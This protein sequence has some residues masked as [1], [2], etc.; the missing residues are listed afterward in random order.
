MSKFAV[1][2]AAG[3][4]LAWGRGEAPAS[5]SG[6]TVR[7]AASRQPPLV[8]ITTIGDPSGL[9]ARERRTSL[10][11]Q[12]Q[13]ALESELGPHGTEI[14]TLD[15]KGPCSRACLTEAKARAAGE[16]LEVTLER[17]PQTL[18]VVLRRIRTRTGSQYASVATRVGSDGDAPNLVQVLSQLYPPA[19][20]GVR[21]GEED[22]GIAPSFARAATAKPGVVTAAPQR[23]APVAGGRRDQRRI[24]DLVREVQREVEAVR[25][26]HSPSPL[27]VDVLDDD[28]FERAL[29]R[30]IRSGTRKLVEARMAKWIAFGIAPNGVDPDEAEESARLGSGLLGFYDPYTKKLYVRRDQGGDSEEDN[31]RIL[32]RVVAHEIEHALQDQAFHFVDLL[33]IADDE[34]RLALKALYE[35]EATV[36]ETAWEA[37]QQHLPLRFAVAEEAAARKRLDDEASLH[38]NG[39]SGSIRDAP[40]ILQEE[41]VLQYV[42]GFALVAEVLKN[43]GFRSVDQMF[44]NPP[45]TTAQVSDPA[46]YFRGQMPLL[47]SKPQA[48]KGTRVVSTGTM[49]ALGTR[50]ALQVCGDPSIASSVGSDL[51]GDAYAVVERRDGSL[52]VL[53]NTAWKKPETLPLRDDD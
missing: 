15:A 17:R 22:G 29:R 21:L 44:R 1:L 48:P 3:L 6:P 39:Y 38:A 46:L 24:T 18:A 41:L 19:P 42:H 49:G 53:W 9:L 34:T 33:K 45:R 31:D 8:A 11:K 37:R 51:A 12:I 23:S 30:S 27:H 25:G 5:V 28:G 16:V 52:G 32:R 35:G 13:V 36:V 10:A 20:Y 4:S 2:A 7:A 40:L 26:I 50:V 47:V 43:G 14:L